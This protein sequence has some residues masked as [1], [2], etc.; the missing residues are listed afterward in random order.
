M[1]G[2]DA[3]IEVL[4][5]VFE[6]AAGGTPQVVLLGGEAGGGKS[7]L[8]AE[9]TARGEGPGAVRDRRA[10]RCRRCRGFP[11]VPAGDPVSRTAS[12]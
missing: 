6:A 8:V 2:R 10:G 7:R 5:D 9:F 3:E 12:S 1:V 11:G 4:G